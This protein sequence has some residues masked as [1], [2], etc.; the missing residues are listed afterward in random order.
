M[1]NS[2]KS[3]SYYRRKLS[4]NKLKRFILNQRKRIKLSI[5]FL[6]FAMFVGI[7]VLGISILK[8]PSWHINQTHLKEAKPWVLN[9]EGNVVTSVNE[10]NKIKFTFLRFFYG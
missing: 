1:Q 10:L 7:C 2:E 4:A 3:Q 5:K 6:K 9:I 8:L